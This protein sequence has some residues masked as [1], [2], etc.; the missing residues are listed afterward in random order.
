[1]E[2]NTSDLIKD[3]NAIAELAEAF[4]KARSSTKEADALKF[5]DRLDLEGAFHLSE[6]FN[7]Y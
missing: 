3:L 5:V 7:A 2:V 1:M 6:T 4:T